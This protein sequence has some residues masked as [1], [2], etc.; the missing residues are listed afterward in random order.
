M[1]SRQIRHQRQIVGKTCNVVNVSFSAGSW[2]IEP[3]GHP[4]VPSVRNTIT[5][6]VLRRFQ[7][8]YPCVKHDLT[9]SVPKP[10]GDFMPAPERA[11][12]KTT[13]SYSVTRMAGGFFTSAQCKFVAGSPKHLKWLNAKMSDFVMREENPVVSISSYLRLTGKSVAEK[14]R[15]DTILDRFEL[16]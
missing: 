3:S 5:L 13:V 6:G 8:T 10:A 4:E 7:I 11:N 16:F 9:R 12:T 15:A 1:L 14:K 2:S